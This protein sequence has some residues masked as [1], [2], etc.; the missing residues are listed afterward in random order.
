IKRLFRLSFR[1]REDIRADIADEFSFHLDMRTAELVRSGLDEAPARAQAVR[2]FG[3]RESSLAALGREGDSME[4]R[5]R[6]AVVASEL[7]QDAA[8]GLRLIAR[9]PGFAAVAI[10]TLAIG[11]GANTAIY[12][13]LDAVLLRPL[14]YPQADRLVLISETLENGN[15]NSSSGGAF[16][17]WRTHQTQFDALMLTGRV[18]ANLRGDA[19]PVRLTGMEV[20]HEFLNVLRIAPLLGRGFVPE[21]DRPG[22]A[23]NVVM[24]TEE[25]WRSRFNSDPSIVGGRIVLDEVPRT[26]IGVLPRGGWILKEDTFFIPAVLMPGTDR[27][28][29][30]PHWAAVFGRLADGSTLARADA[31]LKTIKR[32]RNS[33]YPSFKQ[34]WSVVAQPIPDVIGSVTRAPLLILL[35]A[36]ALV[37]LIACVN[38]ANLLLARGC[39]R[40]QELAVRA[41]LGASGGRLVRQVLTENLVLALL[42]GLA[43]LA[44]AHVGIGWLGRL[45][46][47]AAPITIVPRLDTPVLLFSLLVTAITGPLVGLL[48]ALRVRRPDL[49]GAMNTGSK[50]ASSSGRQRTQSVLVVAEVAFTVVLLASAGL[51]LRSLTRAASTDPGFDPARVLAFDVSLPD[52]SYTSREKKLAFST[53]LTRRLR[54]LAG[55]AATGTGMAIPFS[56]GGYGE[57]FRRPGSTAADSVTGRLDFVSPGYLE[58]LGARLLMGRRLTD[59]DNRADAPR[60]VVINDETVRVLFPKRDAIGQPLTIGGNTWQVV[61]VVAN[62]VDRRLDVASRAFGYVPCAFNMSS[63]SVVVRT[64]LDP[65]SLVA[66]VRAAV[67]GLDGGVAVASPRALDRAMAESMAQR[68]VVLALVGIFAATALA[69]AAIGLYGVMAYGVATRR[70]EFGVRMAFGA[71]RRDLIHDVL[72]GGLKVTAAGLL[73]GVAASIGAARLIASELYQVRGADP[74]VIGGTAFAVTA[75][76]MLACAIPA[77][78]AARL[79]PMAALRTE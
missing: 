36:V 59:V 68:K 11:V 42:G 25:L 10:L 38:V 19:A 62:I 54:N 60:V 29:R 15:P 43:G 79:D 9:S 30:S 63:L 23:N 78:R 31:E 49:S 33:D 24:L 34:N 70:R 66:S 8:L 1:T 45:T 74:F 6:I 21:D 37:L 67:A 3:R 22:G 71:V 77:W 58:A 32:Q 40:Q 52:Q 16:L 27:A 26:V 73:C 72:R 7:R 28:Q 75:V 41:A 55:V 64:P 39:H 12:S 61:G 20:S 35:G 5:S 46:A 14:P 2:E 51:L 57:F 50:G 65:L 53:E 48:P 4:R 56:G 76:A 47:D 13:V 18:S 69:L 44:L 17:D